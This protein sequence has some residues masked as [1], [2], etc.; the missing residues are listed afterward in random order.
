MDEWVIIIIIGMVA[1][2]VLGF[3]PL[4]IFTAFFLLLMMPL[5]KKQDAAM[6]SRNVVT[7]GFWTALI[8]VIGLFAM[9]VLF[10]SPLWMK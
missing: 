1:S 2:L 6:D 10:F 8:T 9:I 5:M 7:S 3:W 4:A